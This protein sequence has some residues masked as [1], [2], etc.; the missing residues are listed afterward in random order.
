M[1]KQVALRVI[2]FISLVGVLFLGYL[3][4]TEIFKQVCALG[5]GTCSNV[6]RLP[7]CVYGLIMYLVLLIIS[8]LGLRS[9][10]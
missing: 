1:E 7:A 10:K 5:T 8:I 6:F 4:F 3:S 2:F 9:K